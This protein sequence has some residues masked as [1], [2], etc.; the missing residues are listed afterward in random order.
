[1]T[2]GKYGL[3]DYSQET[4]SSVSSGDMLFNNSSLRTD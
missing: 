4:V 1:M 2:W 3:H